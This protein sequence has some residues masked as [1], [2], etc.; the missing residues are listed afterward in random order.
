MVAHLRGETS[1]LGT[2]HSRLLLYL[3]MAAAPPVPNSIRGPNPEDLFGGLDVGLQAGATDWQFRAGETGHVRICGEL[4]RIDQPPQSEARLQAV[5]MAALKATVPIPPETDASFAYREE[6]FRL[7]SYTAGGV[8]CFNL[9]HI[10]SALRELAALGAPPA[11]ASAILRSPRGLILVTGPAGSGKSTT[12]AA[13][14]DH[15]NR[16]RAEMILTLED[17]IEYRHRNQRGV[18][19]QLEKG[20][21]FENFAQALRSALRCDPDVILVGEMRDFDTI[22]AALTAAETGHLVLGTLHS[23][24][25]RDAISRIIGAFPSERTGEIRAQLA[26]NLVAVLAQ[27]LV[28]TADRRLVGA[29]ELLLATPGVRHLIADPG[30][31]Y[32]LLANEIATGSARGMVS[33]DQ[34]LEDLWRRRVIDRTEA[35]RCAF[36]PA[37]L[38]VRL[39]R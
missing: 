27:Q 19:R 38:E 39:K 16:H 32:T 22:A 17:P 35:L 9:R 29:F 3:V 31:A 36:D 7:H 8:F 26:K 20:R 30:N 13:A 23:A 5:A 33:M 37:G 4:L 14:L 12:L 11:F 1:A 10:A 28:R 21:D 15:R 34:S 2:T 6:F 18:V 24:T 25:A